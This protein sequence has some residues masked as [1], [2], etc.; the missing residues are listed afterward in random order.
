MSVSFQEGA[1]GENAS[2]RGGVQ[3]TVHMLRTAVDVCRH[4]LDNGQVDT[5]PGGIVRIFRTTAEGPAKKAARAAGYAAI[6]Q[7]Y[8]RGELPALFRELAGFV[9]PKRDPKTGGW[10]LMVC[11]L[12]Q[13][14]AGHWEV[15]RLGKTSG[16]AAARQEVLGKHGPTVMKGRF[17]KRAGQGP[18]G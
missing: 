18:R 4:A 15:W 12:V 9:E 13:A 14:S 10:T 8:G 17:A 2:P 7:G 1:A 5:L 3:L 6:T 16:D 11:A